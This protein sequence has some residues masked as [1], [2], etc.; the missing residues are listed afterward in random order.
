MPNILTTSYVD[1]S[2]PLFTGTKDR[3][4]KN[5]DHLVNSVEQKCQITVGNEMITF[6]KLEKLFGIL[7]YELTYNGHATPLCKKSSEKL[8]FHFQ[9]LNM[10]SYVTLFHSS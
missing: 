9:R 3:S 8:Q 2:T 1:D 7:D 10:N 6:S 5:E 4:L